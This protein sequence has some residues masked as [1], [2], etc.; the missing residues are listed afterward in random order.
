MEFF[1]SARLPSCSFFDPIKLFWKNCSDAMGHFKGK[2][3]KFFLVF[4]AQFGTAYFLKL[5]G[6][7]KVF[8]KKVCVFKAFCEINKL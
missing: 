7:S 8:A 4:F 3:G 6:V 1:F 2:Q 5:L